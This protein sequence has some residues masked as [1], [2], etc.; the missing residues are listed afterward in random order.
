MP[1]ILK[2]IRYF[3]FVPHYNR[4]DCGKDVLDEAP[5]LQKYLS[6]NSLIVQEVF[7]VK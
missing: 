3:T 6:R 4:C 5:R 2:I 1:T 7:P